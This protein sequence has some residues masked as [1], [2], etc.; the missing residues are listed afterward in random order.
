VSNVRAH[1]DILVGALGP[2]PD[3]G[4]PTPNAYGINC[5][6]GPVRVEM[7]MRTRYTSLIFGNL[8]YVR[9]YV[10]FTSLTYDC[11]ACCP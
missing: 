1:Y 11:V 5:G 6:G 7:P 10:D 9:F 3:P 8:Q 4:T 2:E